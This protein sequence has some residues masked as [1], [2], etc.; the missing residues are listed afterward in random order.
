M[1]TSAPPLAFMTREAALAAGLR[2]YFTGQPCTKGHIEE[3][4]VGDR[5]CIKCKQI[6]E[7]RNP[8]RNASKRRQRRERPEHFRQREAR[9]R[10]RNPEK[11]RSNK[12]SWANRHRAQCN[13]TARRWKAANP[14]RVSGHNHFYRSRKRGAEG[15]FSAVDIKNIRDAQRNCCGY[16]QTSF[17]HRKAHIDHITPLSKGGTNWPRNLQ[18]LCER[19]NLTKNNSDPIEYAQ[20][21]GLL[22]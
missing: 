16:C 2:R 3:R 19:C 7:N 10:A 4:L 11:N 8:R 15:R 6:R 22:L 12:T 21:R 18:L 20:R 14:L 1:S 9:L 5:H 17:D 13:A